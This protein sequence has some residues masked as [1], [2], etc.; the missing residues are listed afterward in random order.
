[1]QKLINLILKNRDNFCK[2]N[3]TYFQIQQEFPHFEKYFTNT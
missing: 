1:M 3:K 2:L